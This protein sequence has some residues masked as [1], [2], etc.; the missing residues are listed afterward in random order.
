M[1]E[2]PPK[3]RPRPQPIP[4]YAFPRRLD[5]GVYEEEYRGET[6]AILPGTTDKQLAARKRRIDRQKDKL[7]KLNKKAKR[8]AQRRKD[9]IAA[10]ERA[11]LEAERVRRFGE[12]I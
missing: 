5:P 9:Q 10:N 1:N 11:D 3:P 12:G 8:G 6:L 7:E 4:P 2:D